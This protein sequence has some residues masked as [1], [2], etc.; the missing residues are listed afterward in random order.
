MNLYQTIF[1]RPDFLS[2]VES[3]LCLLFAFVLS[4]FSFCNTA[5]SKIFS[6]KQSDDTMSNNGQPVVG[7]FAFG[8]SGLLR[9]TY[10]F[11]VCYIFTLKYIKVLFDSLQGPS[12]IKRIFTTVNFKHTP[13]FSNNYNQHKSFL[14]IPLN[15]N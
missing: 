10:H 8:E 6:Q 12:K 4:V 7:L 1:L 2:I 13:N 14:I 11:L 5:G 9:S 15:L 3:R